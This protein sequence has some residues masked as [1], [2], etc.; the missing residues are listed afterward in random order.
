MDVDVRRLAAV[1]MH[2]LKGT[3]LRRRII[4]AEFVLGALVMVGV[5]SYFLFTMSGGW[6]LFALWLIGAGLNYVPLS[7]HAISLTKPGA[8]AAELG[9]IDVPAELRRYGVLQLWIFVPLALVFFAVH[10]ALAKS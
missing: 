10:R 2:G 1:D 3:S 6:P 9:A 4:V 5:G 7:V 8:L